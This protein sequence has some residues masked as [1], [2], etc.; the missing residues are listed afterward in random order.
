VGA[1]RVL[2]HLVVPH[3]ISR[4]G[5]SR[6]TVDRIRDAIRDSES[7]HLGEICFVVEGGLPVPFLFMK[8]PARARAEDLFASLRVWDTEH[9][10]GIL[11]YVQRV[12]RRIEIVAD[13]GIA[14]RVAQAEWDAICREM[15]GAFREGRFADGALRAI[16]RCTALLVAHFPSRGRRNP[17]ELPDRPI[18]L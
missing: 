10:S 6:R 13:R 15:E 17:N 12:D 18:L 8:K 2:K 9:N 16:E 3:W 5:F 14:A 11:V 1:G 7:K 4:K